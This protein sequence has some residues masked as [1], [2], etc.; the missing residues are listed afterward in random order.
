M[1]SFVTNILVPYF[2]AKKGHLSLDPVQECIWQLDIWSVHASLEF[3]SWIFD[4]YPWII[5]DYVPGGC[6]GLW[7]PCDVGVQCLLK[8]MVKQSQQTT[9]AREIHSH[10]GPSDISLDTRLGMLRN[11]VPATLVD[12]YHLINNPL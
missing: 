12:A 4:N 2:S 9:I 6:T 3:W 10:A 11:R 7:Q 1:K 5:L 8:L